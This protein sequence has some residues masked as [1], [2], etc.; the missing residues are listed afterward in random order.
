MIHLELN[1]HLVERV[2]EVHFLERKTLDTEHVVGGQI[3]FV[4][5]RGEIVFSRSRT[6]QKRINGLAGFLE[7][8]NLLAQ[9]LQF[10][11]A[12]GEPVRLKNDGSDAIVASG[13]AQGG[14]DIAHRR[15]ALRLDKWDGNVDGSSFGKFASQCQHQN[16]IAF[17]G[18]LLR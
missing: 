4:G 3:D 7:C 15:N 17:Y 14:P 5:D 9:F 13:L 8:H 6:L 16:R 1:T 11:P 10:S 12:G 18:N 2:F